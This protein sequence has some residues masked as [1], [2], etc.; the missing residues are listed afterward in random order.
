VFARAGN[1]I[2]RDYMIY[3]TCSTIVAAINRYSLLRILRLP[4]LLSLFFISST[5]FIIDG[6]PVSTLKCEPRWIDSLVCAGK[7]SLDSGNTDD[8]KRYFAIAFDCGM[9]K[10]SMLYFAAE[11]YMRSF[12]PD[13]A[14]TFNWGLEKTG[15][16]PREIFLEQRSRI[17]RMIGMQQKADSI[18]SIIRK[19]HR[20]D[21]SVNVS[22][23]RNI[24]TLNP[25]IIPPVNKTFFEPG[26]IIDD[27]G[28][29]QI[30]Q[31]LYRYIDSRLRRIYAMLNFSSD[32]KIPTRYSFTDDN[33]TVMKSLSLSLGTGEM[34]RTPELMA[35][36]RLAIYPD[37]N[38][39][40]FNNVLLSFPFKNSYTLSLSHD[41]KWANRQ[42]YDDRT[43]L[44]FYTIV[45]FLKNFWMPS[46][47]AAYHFSKVNQYEN[48]ITTINLYPKLPLG[49]IDSRSLSDSLAA[50]SRYYSDRFLSHTV[51]IDTIMF[52]D[53]D[54]W[55][56]Q[57]SMRLFEQPTKDISATI[58]S[59][60]YLHLP[61]KTNLSIDNYLQC[62]WYPQKVQWFTVDNNSASVNI[63]AMQKAY[64][65][66]YNT[67][68]G[69]YYLNT[70]R[71][72]HSPMR[73]NLIAL[74]KHEKTKVDC[75]LSIAVTIEKEIG[76]LGEL[77]FKTGYVKCFSTLPENSPL[78]SL[79][80]SWE[81]RA[82]WKKDIS[83]IR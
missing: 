70:N 67:S 8:A 11:T 36:H 50:K 16:L 21:L 52:P 4:L 34:P 73:N 71:V 74:K 58:K 66:V 43:D 59:S 33:D 12:A 69:K 24:L 78:I 41:I 56:Y 27:A 39:V 65:V 35:G 30:N 14:L 77:Y 19:K 31:R 76:L 1:A 83:K 60:L 5:F 25:V 28:G 40:H 68:D 46:V 15:H 51:D 37:L 3:S 63:I 80:Q 82:G 81:L 2:V 18:L 57:P 49:Y 53:D 10:D 45:P 22:G 23:S 64:A 44:H 26:E 32:F 47:S 6:A 9:S 62:S 48:D 75:Y 7:R 42:I 61:L 20:Y 54:F 29:I 79:N 38:I 72:D 17:F 13:T 55:N